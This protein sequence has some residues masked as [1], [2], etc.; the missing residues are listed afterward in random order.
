MAV[1]AS[2]QEDPKSRARSEGKREQEDKEQ[3]GVADSSV[4]LLGCA[5]FLPGSVSLT[6]MAC[7]VDQFCTIGGMQQ[8]RGNSVS[9]LAP[10]SVATHPS[11]S[12]HGLCNCPWIS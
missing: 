10:A 11:P 4:E 1:P 5:V 8:R 7:N 9:L 2:E 6:T 3:M 12:A